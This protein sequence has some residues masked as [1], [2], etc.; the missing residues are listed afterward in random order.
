MRVCGGGG[1]IRDALEGKAPQR[2]PQRLLDRRVEEVVKAVGGGYCRLQMPFSLAF[3]IRETVTGHRRGAL[4]VGGGVTSPPPMQPWGGGDATMSD[5]VHT[6]R[7]L[8]LER[9][10]K[11]WQYDLQPARALFLKNTAA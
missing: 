3:A 6:S 8:A 2:R 1:G 4:E 11:N 10:R 7:W 9:R 5:Y